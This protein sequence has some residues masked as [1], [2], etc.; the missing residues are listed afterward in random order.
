[1][2]IT[3][4]LIDKL[5]LLQSGATVPASALRGE[6]VE[7]LLHDGT[8]VSTSHKSHRTI[9]AAV[10]QQLETAL[11]LVDERLG[12]LCKMKELLAGEAS[13]AT[14]ASHTGNSKL[15]STRTCP[16]FP[17]NVYEPLPCRLNGTAFTI[18]S[19]EGCFV[20]VSDWQQ[21]EVPH[22][23]TI[24]GIENMENF[25]LVRRQR[26]MFSALFP[27]KRLLFVSR[28]PQS[29]DLRL[30]LQSI[31]N[32][33][34]HFGDFDLA[35]I[36]IFLTEFHKHLGERASFLIPPDIEVR[37]LQGSAERYK[38]QYLRFHT[39]TSSIPSLQHLI[40]LIH[41]YRR[42]YDQEGYIQ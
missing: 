26:A 19:P 16:G 18:A 42:C 30:W 25:R 33:Y 15:V 17:V 31:P 35:G 2:K 8:L 12:D 32:P 23:V 11:A 10:P 40:T 7:E 6:W 41:R 36:H 22:D 21:F 20:F 34:V 27:A 5:L 3:P 13:R 28:Y 14:Q 39:L 37:L 4:A 38:A 1:M 24:V 9:A 29:T